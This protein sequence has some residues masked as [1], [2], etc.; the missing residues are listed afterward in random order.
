VN[1]R[2]LV[3]AGIALSGL[4]A[5]EALRPRRYVKLLQGGSVADALPQQFPGW[6]SEAASGLVSPEQAGK[7]AKSLYSELLSRSYFDD[8][9]SA[10]IMLLAAYGDTQSDLLQL[11][12]PETCYPAVGFQLELSEPRNLPIGR[13]GIL[14]VRRVIATTESR[15]ENIIYWTRVGETLPQSGEA[16]RNAR[17]RNSMEGF[18]GDGILMRFSMLGDSA[19]AF[20]VLESF[21]PQLLR[22]IAPSMRKAFV[23]TKLSQAVV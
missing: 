16:Q 15:I 4:G 23:G 5:A 18:V 17:L 3:L 10:N 20:A 2:H 11:H 9:D 22:A 8:N 12:R 6:T 14:P 13:A 1:R 7:L 19:A 21:I